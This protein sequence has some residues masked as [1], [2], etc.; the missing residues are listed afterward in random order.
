MD[1]RV[2][3]HTSNN[4]LHLNQAIYNL[5]IENVQ[6]R[7]IGGTGRDWGGVSKI[8]SA[9][10]LVIAGDGGSPEYELVNEHQSY[11]GGVSDALI[12]KYDSVGEV[13]FFMF[14]GGTSSDYVN[15]IAIDNSDNIVVMGFTESLDFPTT[16]GAFNRNFT[17]GRMNVFLAKF[18][19]KGIL[20]FSTLLGA[21]PIFS[22]GSVN[23]DLDQ[24][25]VVVGGTTSEFFPTKNAYQAEFEAQ[26]DGF[27]SKFTPNGTLIFSTFLG[28][29]ADDSLNRVE[30]NSMG[31]YIVY[32]RSESTDFPLV[33]PFG[34][35]FSGDGL[36]LIIA[37]LSADGQALIFSTKFG[38]SQDDIAA[39]LKLDEDDNIIFG[40]MTAS[41]DY[42]IFGG[43][44]NSTTSDSAFLTKI[45]PDGKN[46][47]FSTF[48][49]GN[50]R[51][52]IYCIEITSR[53]NY[54]LTGHIQSKDFPTLNA[55][56]ET[57]GGVD[58]FIAEFVLHY[59]EITLEVTTS[60]ETTSSASLSTTTPI[61]DNLTKLLIVNFGFW[62][63]IKGKESHK[64]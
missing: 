36:D 30:I 42:P 28:G 10:N 62:F 43:V 3:L 21:G 1:T 55:I 16:H 49:D 32:G 15:E 58:L 51:D 27:V 13:V 60:N 40:G 37:K 39:G 52:W 34:D 7:Y 20:V 25:I 18:T 35:E 45:S 8:D 61:L 6:T 23:T 4:S 59:D 53:D 24:N 50:R 2:H 56:Q 46:I 26:E 31:D 29:M 47:L 41:R 12:I 11:G 14:L 5:T 33:E 38:G 57:H 48:I 22:S 64:N 63:Y 17:S 19:P 44:K 54:V 9:D